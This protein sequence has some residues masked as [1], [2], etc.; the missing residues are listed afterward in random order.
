MGV[1]FA[2]GLR[3]GIC[4]CSE[5]PRHSKSCV[6][7]LIKKSETAKVVAFQNLAA[8]IEKLFMNTGTLFVVCDK[9][10]GGFAVVICSGRSG[11]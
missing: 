11:K 1:G 5:A 10:V 3:D 4:R 8:K 6:L 7:Y 9:H 2:R